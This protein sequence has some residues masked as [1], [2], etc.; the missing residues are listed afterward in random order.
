MKKQIL[1]LFFMALSYAA[2]PMLA[3]E[4]QPTK[5][6]KITQTST[7]LSK[8]IIECGIAHKNNETASLEI[9]NPEDI[10]ALLL[11]ETIKSLVDF[12]QETAEDVTEFSI[13]LP[14]ISLQVFNTIF[15]YLRHI[16]KNEYFNFEYKSSEEIIEIL[17]TANY[18]A[19]QPLIDA[20]TTALAEKIKICKQI[21]ENSP[22]RSLLLD[23]PQELQLPI[24]Q[25]I[26]DY[27]LYNASFQQKTVKI[28]DTD[29]PMHI[30]TFN[31]KGNFFITGGQEA[32]PSVYSIFNHNFTYIKTLDDQD[33][34]NSIAYKPDGTL[35][36]IGSDDH[37]VCVYSC[38]NKNHI[39]LQTKLTDHND[40]VTIV[41]FSPN[42]NLLASVSIYDDPSICIYKINE[43]N[44]INRIKKIITS[45]DVNDIIF[46][47]DNKFIITINDDGNIYIYAIENENIPLW[48]KLSDHQ[49]P[50][51]HAQLSPNGKLLVTASHDDD[52]KQCVCIH[53]IADFNNIELMQQLRNIG[54][55]GSI[56]FSP[57]GQ[58]IAIANEYGNV[59]LYDISDP[60]NI[61]TIKIITAINDEDEV[62]SVDFHPTSNLMVILSKKTICVYTYSKKNIQLLKKLN[63]NQTSIFCLNTFSPNGNLMAITCLDKSVHIYDLR[64]INTL[65]QELL[66]KETLDMIAAYNNNNNNN[67]L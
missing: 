60:N 39:S 16:K 41:T 27:L 6:Q 7:T 61:R 8:L 65:T 47:S 38:W 18:L 28:T 50:V 21:N 3:M 34:V 48:K 14:V 52:D 37:S 10:N 24:A 54:D 46:S 59:F 63:S 55:I 40:E 43:H 49:G 17:K 35:M 67:N 36:A 44:T 22:I 9:V 31:P 30:A 64:Y 58:F 53:N 1:T 25:K 5:K 45:S 66:L 51:M 19:V 56:S 12:I 32:N 15:P 13:P 23:L 29:Q 57:N 2:L 11:S 4:E 26:K 33:Q 42:G 20:C 62:I